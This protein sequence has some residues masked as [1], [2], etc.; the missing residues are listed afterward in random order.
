MALAAMLSGLTLA[1]AGLGAVH[2]FAAPLGGNLPVPHGTACAVLLPLVMEA[3]VRA[4]REREGGKGTLERY[5]RVG[6][7][8]AGN[9]SPGEAQAIESAIAFTRE[10]VRYM[11][12]PSLKTFGLREDQIPAL[13]GLARKSSSMRY[14][15]V[16][17]SDE[18]LHQILREA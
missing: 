11:G 17:L 6:R 3:N 1:N 14:N 9:E 18:T 12:I 13:V 5:A 2:G 7:I 4:L 10:L 16:T 8:M 15:P